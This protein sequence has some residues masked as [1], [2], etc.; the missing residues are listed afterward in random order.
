MG[1]APDLQLLLDHLR[2]VVVPDEIAGDDA[3]EVARCLF[4]LRNVVDHLAATLIG[5][6]DRCGVAAGQGRTLREL[7]M[8]L[9]CAPAVAERLV[10]VGA[11]LPLLPTLAA[12]ACDGTVS[13]EHVDA[14][15]KGINHIRARSPG[16]VDE[17][18]RFR[19]VTDLLGQFFSGATPADIG[20]RARKLGNRA[21]AEGGL[22][23][24]EDRSVNTLDH[25]VTS[26]G[27]LQ[28][29]ADLD[30]EVGAK[31]VAAVEELSAPRPEPDG[32]PDTRSASR[33]RA[34]ALETMLDIAAR[35]GD[36]ASAP[37]TQLLVTVPA[38]TPDM[39]QLEFMGSISTMT[40][41]RLT[42]DTAVTTVVVDDEQV[43]LGMG[44]EKRLFPP[45]LRKAL[46]LR[47]Q[48]CIKCGAPPGRTHAHHIV[49]WTH[50]GETS[51]GNGCLLCPA[52]HANVH[53]DGWDVVM[54]LD[55]HPWLIPPPAVDPHRT[56]IPAY[57]RRTMRLDH[58]A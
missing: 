29:R 24:A 21:A 55:R 18:A 53:H 34:D 26:D 46:Y 28:V 30:A 12:H 5:V 2:D 56:P 6:L 38:D 3:L 31:L 58:A 50:G 15:V 11:A 33:R 27:R 47:D 45:H 39:G 23:A 54:G 51:L 22:P 57:N 16:E 10:R 9:G 7:L 49:H 40:L 17:E 4:R 44:R 48:C 37:R 32:S 20:N 41:E 52:C 35:G 36:V 43:P 42:C 13:G 8:S 1:I 19:Q 14:I 25:R